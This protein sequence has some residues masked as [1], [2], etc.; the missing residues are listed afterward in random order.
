MLKR[1]GFLRGFLLGTFDREPPPTGIG[2]KL[3]V[4]LSIEDLFEHEYRFPIVLFDHT[5]ESDWEDWM[6]QRA[7]ATEGTVMPLTGN[8][9]ELM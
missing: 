6:C 2:T 5:N 7:S 8:K 9:D 4:T 1:G 3:E